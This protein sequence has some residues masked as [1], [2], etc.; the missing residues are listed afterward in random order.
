M[1]LRQVETDLDPDLIG[2]VGV[3]KSKLQA[4]M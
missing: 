1:V 4:S 3:N 2:K